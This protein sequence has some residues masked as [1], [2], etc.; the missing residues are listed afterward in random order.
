MSE[1]IDENIVDFLDLINFTLSNQ[2]EER[3]R[4]R[5]SSSFIKLFQ[6]KLLESMDNQKPIKQSTLFTYLTKRCKYS[7]EEVTNFFKAIEIDLY[8]PIIQY[9]RKAQFKQT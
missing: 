8:D 6:L 9:D 2:F 5:F 4:H 3:W 7:E 1:N